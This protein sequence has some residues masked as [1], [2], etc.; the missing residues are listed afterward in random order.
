MNTTFE[1]T[2]FAVHLS[3][4]P[5]ALIEVR[6]ELDLC[7]VP[8]FEAALGSLDLASAPRAV[9]DLRRLD[10]IDAAGLHAVL[11]LNAACLEVSTALTI[12]PGPRHVQRVFALAGVDGHLRFDA[13]VTGADMG[14]DIDGSS[15]G[16]L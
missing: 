14:E 5:S 11:R 1:S 9:L 12:V 16:R 8:M 2:A 10:F 4:G 15:M 6:G 13:G 7:A 3:Q